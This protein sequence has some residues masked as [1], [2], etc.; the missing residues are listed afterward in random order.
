MCSWPNTIITITTIITIISGGDIVTI[1]T[2]IITITATTAII[3]GRENAGPKQ[4]PYGVLFLRATVSTR[5]YDPRAFSF[6]AR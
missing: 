5:C 1:T 4:D 2:I 6:A 3:D